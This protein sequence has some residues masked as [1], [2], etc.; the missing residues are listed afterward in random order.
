MVSLSHESVHMHSLADTYPCIQQGTFKLVAGYSKFFLVPNVRDGTQEG[1]AECLTVII[2][3]SEPQHLVCVVYKSCTSMHIR[4]AIT[5]AVAV[6]I[7]L[8]LKER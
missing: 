7:K 1:E 3:T 6:F 2:G 4:I 8:E 5:V